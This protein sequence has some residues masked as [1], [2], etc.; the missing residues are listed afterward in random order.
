VKSTSRSRPAVGLLLD[1]LYNEYASMVVAA[2]DGECARRGYDLLCFAGGSLHSLAGYELQRNHCFELAS[3]HSLDGLIVLSLSSTASVMKDFL[4]SFESIP[5]CSVGIEV[6]GYAC[7]QADNAAGM[8]DA[9]LHLITVHARRQIG[10]LRGPTDNVE[11]EIRYRAYRDALAKFR[12]PFDL[13]RVILANFDDDQGRVAMA[14]LLDRGVSLDALVGAN[15][16]SVLGALRTLRERGIRVPEDIAIVGFDD[17]EEARGASPSLATVRQPYWDMAERA[18]DYLADSFEHEISPRHSLLASHFVKRRSCGCLSEGAPSETQRALSADPLPFEAAFARRR[19]ELCAEL[20]RAERTSR[21]SG[22]EGWS[23]LLLDAIQAAVLGAP[24]RELL[25]VLDDMLARTAAAEGDMG[26]WQHAVSVL[27][28]L[29]LPCVMSDSRLWMR[30]ED[31]WQRVRVLLADAAEREQR[32]LRRQAEHSAGILTD[33]SE[34]LITSFDV[35][36]LPRALADRLPALDIAS[37][38][39]ALYDGP[40]RPADESRMIVAYE[41]RK[42]QDIPA[43]GARFRTLELVPTALR[44]ERRKSVVVEPLFFEN[45]QL[46]FSVLELGPKRRVVYELLRELISAALRGAELVRRV[47][48]EAGQR[49]KAE[50][51]RLGRELDIA[52][53]IQTSILPRNLVVENLDVAAVMLPAAEVGG[54]YYE[55]LP[56]PGGCWLGIGDV[57]GHGLRPGLV[58]MMLQS[59]VAA[60]LRR[61][62]DAA[63]SDVLQTVNAVLYENVRE[64]LGQD[65]HATLTLLRYF[66]TGKLVF[67]GAHEEIVIFREKTGKCQRIP[68]L[69][70]WVAATRDIRA[71]TEDQEA[72]LEDGDVLLLYTDGVIEAADAAGQEYGLTRL[73]TELELTAGQ[74][75]LEIRDRLLSS[76]RSFLHEQHDDI[77]LLVARHRRPAP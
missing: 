59:V 74:P 20:A 27:R 22:P 39:V 13:N 40:G 51:E 50:K 26:A 11:A 10:F 28:R 12:I 33:T 14:E 55:V 4:D 66:P 6:P 76:V 17:S 56:G 52:T 57:A 70:T 65:E 9:V 63:P 19:Q 73:C 75:V 47:A 45:H 8:R 44:G 53:H 34:S 68:T 16:H 31:M 21:V 37:A 3:R 23:D 48:E 25:S 38:Y 5:I 2:F 60:L 64:R 29:I 42:L 49:E 62:F 46:G 32:G 69:G 30:F 35:E 61:D 18:L 77:A 67:A 54:D 72:Q 71:A 58:M 36:S 1:A 24:D 41:R 43:L 15:D 7:V